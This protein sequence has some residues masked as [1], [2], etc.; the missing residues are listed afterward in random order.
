MQIFTY[1]LTDRVRAEKLEQEN[2]YLR[3]EMQAELAFRI[4]APND[5]IT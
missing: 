5:A 2:A 1:D 4:L 3:E